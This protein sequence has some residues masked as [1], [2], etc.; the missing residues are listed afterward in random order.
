MWNWQYQNDTWVNL[1]NGK[2]PDDWV[3][4]S[5]ITRVFMVQGAACATCVLKDGNRL[6]TGFTASELMKLITDSKQK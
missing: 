4:V 3:R 6:A 5:T 1:S 2:L